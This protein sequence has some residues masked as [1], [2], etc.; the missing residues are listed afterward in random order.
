MGTYSQLASSGP[1]AGFR[2]ETL[3]PRSIRHDAAAAY[4]V[5]GNILRGK[6][7]INTSIFWQLFIFPRFFEDSIM[8]EEQLLELCARLNKLV[9]HARTLPQI[10]YDEIKV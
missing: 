5:I 3:W 2:T 1:N 6:G 10:T 9:Q 7:E 4:S 8:K